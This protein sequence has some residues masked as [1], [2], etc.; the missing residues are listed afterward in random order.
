MRLKKGML[1]KALV[2]TGAVYF[3]LYIA[4]LIGQS[5]QNY[6]LWMAGGATGK[7]AK[8]NYGFATS[9]IKAISTAYGWQ[10]IFFLCFALAAMFVWFKFFRKS[11]GIKDKERNLTISA[12]GTYGTAGWMNDTVISRD[13]KLTSIGNS[14]GIPLG[15]LNGKAVVLPTDTMLN[16]H[17]AV[18]GATGTMK[19]RAFVRPY[20]MT[21]IERGESVILTDSKGELYADLAEFARNKGYDVKVLNLVMPECSDSWNSIGEIENSDLMASVFSNVIINNTIKGEKTDQ[22]WDAAQM[23]LLK[24]LALYVDLNTIYSKSEKNMDTL[25][26]LFTKGEDQDQ[27]LYSLFKSLPHTHKA[28][29]PFELFRQSSEVVRS[30]VIIGLGSR[31]QV[32]QNE[33]IRAMTATSEIDLTKPAHTKCIYFCIISDQDSTLDFLSSLFFSFL[34]I[35]LV[36]YADTKG[37]GGKCDIPVNF[38]LEEFP[39]IGSILDINK[40]LNT[41]RSRNLNVSIVFQSIAGIKNRYPYD[42]WQEI[43]GCMDT[44]LFLGCSDPLTATYVSD[45]LG[46]ATVAVGT[47]RY[48]KSPI[49][50]SPVYQDMHSVGKRKLMTPDE[51]LRLPNEQALVMIRGNKPLKVKKLDYTRYPQA[52]ELVKSNAADHVP[53]WR[54]GYQPPRSAP[55]SDPPKPGIVQRI[56]NHT[57]LGKQT[58]PNNL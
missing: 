34:F 55:P 32:F 46:D 6:D 40:K 58:N 45:F 36:N 11:K 35:K 17:I 7:I 26:S 27:N 1:E 12:E 3:I 43:I 57:G 9:V 51:V 39:N 20:C 47:E 8:V 2:V 10:A 18:Y 14:C 25:Y 13:L 16:K 31:L 15:E 42:V 23:N 37:P 19:S 56:R 53:L 41:V 5:R 30:S 54:G 22:F 50:R 33:I 24:A 49:M 38:V 4:G 29:M 21:A 28:K 48:T 44:Q 52:K